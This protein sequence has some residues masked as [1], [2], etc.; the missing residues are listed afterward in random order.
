MKSDAR[1]YVDKLLKLYLALPDTPNRTSRYD[2]Q[3][4]YDLHQQNVPLET[5][6]AAFLLASARRT[7]RDPSY[8]P[9]APIR[10]LHY[11]LPVIQEVTAA[12]LP[13]GYLN[14]LRQKLSNHAAQKSAP[15]ETR[16]S[17]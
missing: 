9:L 1:L 15:T 5:V 3:L 7:L 8:P 10:S 11:F 12:P 17:G 6:E 2:R 16:L 14:Y 4:A 13:K